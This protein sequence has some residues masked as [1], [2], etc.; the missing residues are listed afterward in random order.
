MKQVNFFKGSTLMPIAKN[1]SGLKCERR[2]S[3]SYACV[4][5]MDI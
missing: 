1:D 2:F 4:I 5:I 3:I